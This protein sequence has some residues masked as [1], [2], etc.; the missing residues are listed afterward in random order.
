[1]A[2][3]LQLLHPARGWRDRE[4]LPVSP[5]LLA[6]SPCEFWPKTP[7]HTTFSS[8][9]QAGPPALTGPRLELR[10]LSQARLSG[11]PAQG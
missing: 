8:C 7:A 11:C 10:G 2:E 3:P 1:M 6:A 5:H 4:S 9:T